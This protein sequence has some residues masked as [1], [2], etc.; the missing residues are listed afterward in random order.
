MHLVEAILVDVDAAVAAEVFVDCLGVNLIVAH[1]GL[2]GRREHLEVAVRLGHAQV[3][4]PGLLAEGAVAANNFQRLVGGGSGDGKF[5]FDLAAVC[6]TSEPSLVVEKL[7]T[8]PQWQPPVKVLF[9][10]ETSAAELS[11]V[12]SAAVERSAIERG[13]ALARPGVLELPPFD[14]GL[15]IL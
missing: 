12:E 7:T 1:L 15:I 2:V 10:S 9:S 5:V 13:L 3:S 14:F 8:Y 6:V 11:T 4:H